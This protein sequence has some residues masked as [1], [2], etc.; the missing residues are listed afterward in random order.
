MKYPRPIVQSEKKSVSLNTYFL[1]QALFSD[2]NLDHCS[3]Y[4]EKE[5]HRYSRL[6]HVARQLRAWVVCVYSR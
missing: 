2:W 3:S 1:A 5:M 6:H 4:R